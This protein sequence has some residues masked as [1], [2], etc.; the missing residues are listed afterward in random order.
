M[1][2]ANSDSLSYQYLVVCTGV[3][4]G[5]RNRE[6]ARSLGRTG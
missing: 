3:K 6:L 1:R 4:L 2:L 5:G